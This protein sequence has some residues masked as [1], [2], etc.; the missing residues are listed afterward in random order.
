V[1]SAE[2]NNLSIKYTSADNMLTSIYDNV[3]AGQISAATGINPSGCNVGQNART[4]FSY[5]MSSGGMSQAAAI[6]VL[7]NIQSESGFNTAA[8]GD[9]M[10]RC[11]ICGTWN[12]LKTDICSNGH[13]K[14][15]SPELPTSF[16][17]CQWHFGRGD[18]MKEVAGSNWETNLSGQLD[19]LMIEL[20]GGYK[21]VYDAILAVPNSLLGAMQAADI[22][23]RRFEVPANPDGASVARQSHAMTF[24]SNLV[25]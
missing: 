21:G 10:W 17:L 4:A 12:S 15:N 3:T 13:K 22:F 18:R 25:Q 14:V 2:S 7:A 24:W 20:R 16:G 5:L 23:V 1:S 8:K 9:Y 19:Y 6:G 11:R